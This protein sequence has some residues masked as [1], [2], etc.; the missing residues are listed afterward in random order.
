MEYIVL[1]ISLISTVIFAGVGY[2]VKSND[3]KLKDLDSR[4]DDIEKIRSKCEDSCWEE[5]G[6]VKK[7]M[8]EMEHNY[9]AKFDETKTAIYQ[10]TNELRESNH[11]TR[12]DLTSLFGELSV[13]I[14]S[15]GAK[16][17]AM[18]EK[19]NDF[20]SESKTRRKPL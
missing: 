19:L 1:A 11:K 16:F 7:R 10:V 13:S 5:M 18:A 17:E 4:L 14:A 2:Y 12:A 20:I 9:I 6:K 3:Q 8:H 15:F